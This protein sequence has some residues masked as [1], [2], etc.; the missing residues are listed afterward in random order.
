MSL[1]VVHQ[2]TVKYYFLFVLGKTL[3]VKRDIAYTAVSLY[4]LS[5]KFLL[6]VDYC[7]TDTLNEY[8]ITRLIREFRALCKREGKNTPVD[9]VGAVT[10]GSKLIAD[11]GKAA[12]YLLTG[13]RLLTRR[14]VTGLVCKYARTELRVVHQG[15]VAE[16]GEYSLKLVG[17]LAVS[18][19]RLDCR[20]RLGVSNVIGN[21]PRERKFS[22][23][24]RI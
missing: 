11:V 12:K 20:Y 23:T 16:N 18:A 1:I 8:V 2:A 6:A 9:T 24:Q 5:R 22:K 19:S 21:T 4:N 7:L 3:D 13:S 15:V 10:L 14:T 17:S